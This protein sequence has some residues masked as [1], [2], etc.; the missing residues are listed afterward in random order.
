MLENTDHAEF[1][2]TAEAATRL[3]LNPVTVHRWIR[4]GRLPAI[5][6]GGSAGYRIRGEDLEHVLWAQYGD[7]ADRIRKLAGEAS[8][9][10][11]ALFDYS[12][13]QTG[14]TKQQAAE[15][16]MFFRDLSKRALLLGE[17]YRD[18]KG[19]Y[20]P[21]RRMADDE[22]PTN[23][24]VIGGGGQPAPLASGPSIPKHGGWRPGQRPPDPQP[25]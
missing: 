6:L 5:D 21:R 16:G 11:E 22:R 13:G 8:E 15:Q 3:R 2:K 4:S 14:D 20:R 10:A 7:L 18:V 17:H 24:P 9:I 23:Q 12:D 19:F 1:Y 25:V